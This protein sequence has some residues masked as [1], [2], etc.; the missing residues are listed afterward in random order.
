MSYNNRG[1]QTGIK[2]GVF[3]NAAIRN[4]CGCR[5][6][7]LVCN[8]SEEFTSSLLVEI[9][10]YPPSPPLWP[11]NIEKSISEYCSLQRLVSG[12]QH[13]FGHNYLRAKY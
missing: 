1:F 5:G 9:M 3:L 8:Q 11:H 6:R 12:P 10:P 2:D 7:E 4:S 13:L